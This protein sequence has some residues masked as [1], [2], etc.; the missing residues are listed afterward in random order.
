LCDRYV[1][2]RC[3]FVPDN[4]CGFQKDSS[5]DPGR[6]GIPKGNATID[7]RYGYDYGIFGDYCVECSAAATADHLKIDDYIYFRITP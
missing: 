1:P 4:S 7:G 6:I 2:V 5:K 3:A